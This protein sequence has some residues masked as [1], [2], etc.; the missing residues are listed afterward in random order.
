M[1]CCCVWVVSNTLQLLCLINNTQADHDFS[2][3]LG[4]AVH[5][6]SNPNHRGTS[7]NP[8]RVWSLKVDDTAQWAAQ[9]QTDQP[10]RRG[11]PT[12]HGTVLRVGA[13]AK[14]DPR[15][16]IGMVERAVELRVQLPKPS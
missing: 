6:A 15:L 11:P 16:S 8:N 12:H 13:S 5:E 14:P 1:L 2:D 9:G 3:K 7:D 4:G 10:S